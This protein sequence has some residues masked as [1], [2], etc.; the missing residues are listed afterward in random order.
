MLPGSHEVSVAPAHLTSSL[1][2]LG[3]SASLL[4]MLGLSAF[5]LLT[6]GL[7]AFLWLMLGLF[8]GCLQERC[9]SASLPPDRAV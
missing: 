6:L 4:L 8:A 1:L 5:L 7:S 3:L 2:M 9:P